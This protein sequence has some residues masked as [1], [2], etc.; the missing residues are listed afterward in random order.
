[1]TYII[2]YLVFSIVIGA[3]INL[4][5]NIRFI[6]FLFIP[7]LANQLFF[8]Y[9]CYQ[10]LGNTISEY[11]R[12]DHIGFIFIT[13]ISI[14]SIPVAIHTIIYNQNRQSGIRQIQVHNSA[15]ILL[16][17]SMNGTLISNHYGMLWS[18]LEATTVASALLIYFDRSAISLEAAWKYFFVSSIGLALAYVGIL[19]LGIAGQ[20]SGHYDLTISTLPLKIGEMSPLWL[21]IS[22]IFILVG[23][24]VKMGVVPLFTVDIDAKDTT[25]SPVGALFSGGLMNV[26]FVSIF[27]FYEVFSQTSILLWMNHVLI[28]TGLASI[29]FAAVY[30]LKVKNIKR[31][32]AYSSVEHGGLVLIAF[33]CGGYGYMA[34]IAHLIFHS[35]IKST[36]FLQIGQLYRTFDDKNTVLHGKYFQIYPAGAVVLLIGF[37]CIMALPPSGMF[38]SEFY[39]FGAIFAH[40]HW[41]VGIT[42]IILLSFIFYSLVKFLLQILF[43]PLPPL[44]EIYE[45]INP[46]ESITQYILLLFVIWMGLYPS[47]WLIDFISY[48]VAHLPK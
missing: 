23:F 4:V 35:F 18:F 33:G 27:R 24:S 10:N 8:N 34:G 5:K 48:S 29:L 15:L 2:F 16:I 1:M 28:F 30:L 9:F 26:G 36:L 41:L 43:Q 38:L 13:I 6:Y 17:I 47:A 25:P 39:I 14:I 7:F 31:I 21:K 12:F 45:K 40:Y 19:F 3:I 37:I 22:F 44:Q 11:F 46:L 20:A 32:L 42:T